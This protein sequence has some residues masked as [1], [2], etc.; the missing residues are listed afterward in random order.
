MREAIFSLIRE[1]S[2]K[3]KTGSWGQA[4]RMQG[5]FRLLR[6]MFCGDVRSGEV[7]LLARRVPLLIKRPVPCQFETIHPFLDG[8]EGRGDFLIALFLCQQ[9]L[10]RSPSLSF[11]LFQKTPGALF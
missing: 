1:N 4:R 11:R 6:N 9:D 10:L 2:G 8:T 3:V 5:L 7:L